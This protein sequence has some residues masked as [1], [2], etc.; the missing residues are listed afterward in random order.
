MNGSTQTQKYTFSYD[1][2]GNR[3]QR[4]DIN[5]AS[6]AYVWDQAS[7]LTSAGTTATYAYNGDGLRMTKTVSGT[8]EQ[9]AWDLAEGLPALIR[10]GNTDYITDDS[11]VP[12]E[13]IAGGTVYFFHQ[14]QL[15][16]TRAMTDGAGSVIETYTYDV[17]GNVATSTGSVSNP[18]QFAGQYVDSETGFSYMRARYYD[19]T[20]DQFISRDPIVSATRE[21]YV[22]VNDNGLNGADPSG[23]CDG[24]D[25]VCR[26]RQSAA[27]VARA[28]ASAVNVLHNGAVVVAR[29]VVSEVADQAITTSDDL[30]SGNPFRFAK[31][32]GESLFIASMI[33]PGPGEEFSADQ[34]VLVEIAKSVER[35]GVTRKEAQILMDWAA[36]YT[37]R[38]SSKAIHTHPWGGGFPHIRIGPV[39]H[40]RVID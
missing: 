22:Y 5:S 37:L 3:T 7:R 10:D 9:F 29:A 18:F 4:T 16:S 39:N 35:C 1:A 17:L 24:W 23:L 6:T 12:I 15:G 11:G 26:A 2:N 28:A 38:G 27:S 31:G 8:Q 25:L 13:R 20:T 34:R 32:V 19:P 14:D 30:R 36:E 40:I 33:V 21:P